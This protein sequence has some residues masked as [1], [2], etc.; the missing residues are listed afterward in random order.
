MSVVV[1][2]RLGLAGL[3]V[4]S[5]KDWS[6][7]LGH[8]WKRL[9]KAIYVLGAIALLHYFIQSKSNVSE[10]VF[11]SGLFAWLLL[12]R[13]LPMAWQRSLFVQLGL[14]V[15]SACVAAGIEFAWY[16]LATGINPWRVLAA[17]ETLR[18]GLRP[19]H[20]VALTGLA[21]VVLAAL[22]RI[23]TPMWLRGRLVSSPG[24]GG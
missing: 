19:A 24:A 9:H 12:W 1:I 17:S 7:R 3:G 13:A 18:F 10:P 8:W 16:A 21:V 6:W 15:V 14:A 2:V 22:R 5:T 20:Y 23:K 11:F 4:T